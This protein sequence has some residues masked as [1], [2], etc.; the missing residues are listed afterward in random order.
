MPPN[1]GVY[2]PIPAAFSKLLGQSL[3][4]RIPHNGIRIEAGRERLKAAQIMERPNE[5]SVQLAVVRHIFEATNIRQRP[6]EMITNLGQGR[7]SFKGTGTKL[8]GPPR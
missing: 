4:G 2:N 8:P 6:R 1:R 5:V 7:F 3:A